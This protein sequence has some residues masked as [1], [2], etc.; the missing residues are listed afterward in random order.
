MYRFTANIG[1]QSFRSLY[2]KR[3]TFYRFTTAR[4]HYKVAMP[5]LPNPPHGVAPWPN[6]DISQPT[7][8]K[9]RSLTPKHMYEYMFW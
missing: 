6:L 7:L 1:I 4:H 9:D 5:M 3:K 8:T 2:V